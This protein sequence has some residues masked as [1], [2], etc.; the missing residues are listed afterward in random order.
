MSLIVVRSMTVTIVH[1]AAA[2]IAAA[3]SAD[4]KTTEEEEAAGTAMTAVMTRVQ[5]DTVRIAHVDTM[6]TAAR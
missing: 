3:M 2:L 4:A 6:M 1:E 5:G